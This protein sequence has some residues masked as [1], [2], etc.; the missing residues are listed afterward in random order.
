MD[1][2]VCLFLELIPDV[3]VSTAA[4]LLLENGFN[5]FKDNRILNLFT[6][7]G[8]GHHAWLATTQ[9]IAPFVIKTT[10]GNT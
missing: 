4:K 3:L 1:N 2:D 5:I 10:A 9:T 8:N 6:I 7:L